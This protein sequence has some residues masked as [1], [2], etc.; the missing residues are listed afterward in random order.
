MSQTVTPVHALFQV[1]NRAGHIFLWLSIG[2]AVL[3]AFAQGL[4]TSIAVMTESSSRWTF[5]FRLALLEHW[6]WIIVS[7][8]LL[9]SL[10]MNTL[11]FASGNSSEAVSILALSS[12]TLLAVVRHML[13]AWQHRHYILTRW[14]A[15]TG[16]SRTT[17]RRDQVGLCGNAEAWKELVRANQFKLSRLQQTPSDVYGWRL[18]PVEGV[19]YDPTD[20]LMSSEIPISGS[21]TLK[22][23]IASWVSTTT[24]MN[25]RI[26]CH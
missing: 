22:M 23:V 8:L 11:A 24:P 4:V 3:T 19:N 7:L 6:W 25:L 20:I 17:I 2:L 26:K 13:P 12:A 14:L 21:S 16:D 15:W 9:A 5:H 10:T 1:N 18:W